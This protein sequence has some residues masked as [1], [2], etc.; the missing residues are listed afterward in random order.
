MP[1][2]HRFPQKA[3]IRIYPDDVMLEPLHLDAGSFQSPTPVQ[4]YHQIFADDAIGL[5]VGVWD[6]T[7][8]QEAFGPYP[9]DEFITV[10][11]GTFAI[12]D[13]LGGAVTGT[14]G[15]S[16]TFRNGIPVS[17]KQDGYLRKIY[18]TLQPLDDQPRAPLSAMGG[19][20]VLD[21]ARQVRGGGHGFDRVVREILFRNDA[22]TMEVAHSVY[23]AMVQ[24]AATAVAHELCR[25]ISG[26]IALTDA[27]GKIARFGPGDHF[28]V[29][30][31]AIS[32]RDISPGT[33]AWHVLIT[34]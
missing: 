24:P 5:A 1:D 6:T 32:A 3:V 2:D 21:P 33:A 14:A 13:G 7:T 9:G 11:D 15:Q 18:L 20:R 12:V 28:F 25:V 19:V 34:A 8:T 22:G 16:A 29:P 27:A 26:E 31:G 23:P 17:W 30:R 4:N 10:L